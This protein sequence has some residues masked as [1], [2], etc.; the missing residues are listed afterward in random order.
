M[1]VEKISSSQL[2]D[3]I[4]NELCRSSFFASKNYLN[5][6]S[7]INGQGCY[8]V[9]KDQDSLLA[10]MPAVE[11]GKSP[12]KRVQSMPDGTYST[13]Y[14]KNPMDDNLKIEL[15]KLIIQ[16]LLKYG[17]I[18]IDLFDYNDSLKVV[19]KFDK[20]T[21]STHLIE[22][23][24]KDWIPPDKKIQSELRKAKRENVIIDQFDPEKHFGKF[25]ELMKSTEARHGRDPKYNDEFYEKLAR[26]S[27]KDTR[28]NWLWCEHG[29]EAVSSHINI[30]ENEMLLN[31]QVFFDK[32]FS[33][34]KANQ[35]MIYR[36]VKEAQ[37]KGC[38][39]F[40]MG[41]SPEDA[42]GL[43]EYKKKY[44]SVE[45]VYPLYR[46]RSVLGKIV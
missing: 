21:L 38:R 29:G 16:L 15:T 34:L 3:K 36:S 20:I 32:Q 9:V 14:F 2:D 11:F 6:W 43:I 27:S 33:F 23:T 10:I 45:Y 28:V 39:Y 8:F 13:I 17:Y 22:I 7:A 1:I 26:L 4:I 24:D 40:N 42:L 41:A 31:W 44:G 5:L 18:K 37:L 30:Y 46:Y 25:I 35:L 19:D 12:V